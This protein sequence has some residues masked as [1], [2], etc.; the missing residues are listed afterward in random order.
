MRAKSE[1]IL[2]YAS[3]ILTSRMIE[4]ILEKE[5]EETREIGSW[6]EEAP[7]VRVELLIIEGLLFMGRNVQISSVIAR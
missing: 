1:G 7:V 3:H 5:G 2:A 4:V 6:K